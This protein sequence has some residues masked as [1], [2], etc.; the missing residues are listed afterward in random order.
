MSEAAV[1]V[2]RYMLFLFF[3]VTVFFRTGYADVVHHIG[4]HQSDSPTV[5]IAINIMMAVYDKLGWKLIVDRYPGERS[6]LMAN[7]GKTDGD[8]FRI[9]SIGDRYI[10][11]IKVPVD[12]IDVN[13][14]VFA[15]KERAVSI[16]VGNLSRYSIG[17]YRGA[18]IIE[19][20]TE[21]YRR[22]FVN[23]LDSLFKMLIYDRVDIVIFPDIDGQVL[24]SLISD[25]DIVLNRT[26]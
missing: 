2:K 5:T 25:S 12:Y 13:F 22:S 24:V 10:N 20:F 9:D 19:Q 23:N 14:Y 8:L 18:K 4:T 21:G 17:V 16:D 15:K 3:S 26:A 1:S 6:L 11:L 7:A